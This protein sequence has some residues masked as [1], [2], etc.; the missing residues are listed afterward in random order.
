MCTASTEVTTMPKSGFIENGKILPAFMRLLCSLARK[1]TVS[2]GWKSSP[3]SHFPRIFIKG[4]ISRPLIK[5]HAAA[6]GKSPFIIFTRLL[7]HC[8]PA[9]SLQLFQLNSVDWWMRARQHHK[10]HS[11]FELYVLINPTSVS[12]IVTATGRR[13]LTPTETACCRVGKQPRKFISS[14]III[15]IFSTSEKAPPRLTW[16]ER[17]RICC[18]LTTRAT[19]CMASRKV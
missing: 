7:R 3:M 6:N 8:W 1:I 18:R 16:L 4:N 5:S 12:Q 15:Q 19:L 14:K 2:D 11:D 13:L 17:T 10:C 9:N